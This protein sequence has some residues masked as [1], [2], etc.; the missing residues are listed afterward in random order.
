MPSDR[1]IENINQSAH[2]DAILGQW[3]QR[4][5]TLVIYPEPTATGDEDIDI[6]YAAYHVLNDGASG[7]DTIPDEDLDIMA[8]VTLALYLRARA[9]EIALEP[10]YAEGLQRVTKRN[11]P[12]NLRDTVRELRKGLIGKYGGQGGAVVK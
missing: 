8:D 12:G 10:D 1:V 5:E 3:E 4:N 11:I 2:I 9:A 6:V 7:Y